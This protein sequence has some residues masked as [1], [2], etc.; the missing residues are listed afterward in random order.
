MLLV[1][2]VT[3]NVANGIGAGTNLRSDIDLPAGKL[4]IGVLEYV[5][6]VTGCDVVGVVDE[7]PYESDAND[8]GVVDINGR[9]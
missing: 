8:D 6:Y 1:S 5:L 7:N 4:G 3:R 2:I 9:L